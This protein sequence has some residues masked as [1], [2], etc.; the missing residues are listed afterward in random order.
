MKVKNKEIIKR[1]VS[2]VELDCGDKDCK[3]AKLKLGI[4]V[5]DGCKCSKTK[6][7]DVE[8]YLLLQISA[9]QYIIEQYE[10]EEHR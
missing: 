8:Y 1:S 2:D 9:M 3:Y 7:E 6:G 10:A 4:R 5:G